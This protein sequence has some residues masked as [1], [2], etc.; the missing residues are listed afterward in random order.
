[1]RHALQYPVELKFDRLR[2][3]VAEIGED[4]RG[5]QHEAV[6]RLDLGPNRLAVLQRPAEVRVQQ[7]EVAI[8]RS[9]SPFCVSRTCS[10]EA[11]I[12]LMRSLS[13]RPL[14]TSGGRPSSVSALR[15]ARQ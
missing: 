8:Y 5:L 13:R 10:N 2:G 12:A 1:M 3:V 11:S 6:R 4:L 14:A 15:T 9:K 7:G